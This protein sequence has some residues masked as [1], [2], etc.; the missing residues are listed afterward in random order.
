MAVFPLL[1]TTLVF[2]IMKS[3]LLPLACALLMCGCIPK[4]IDIEL[5][6]TP[7]KLVVA[8]QVI[9]DN[10]LVVNLTRSFN[11]LEG[12]Q[13]SDSTQSNT[14]FIKKIMVENAVVTVS[15][16]G[17]TDTLQ[18]VSP[19]IY[20]SSRINLYPYSS[21]TLY[22]YDPL[23]N[24]SVT[25][26]SG[27]IPRKTFDTIYPQVI[28]NPGD[29][30]IRIVHEL[31]DDPAAENYYVINYIY[32]SATVSA[33]NGTTSLLDSPTQLDSKKLTAAEPT[34]LSDQ[35]FTNGRY[36]ASKTLEF[37][38]PNDSIAVILSHI[39]KDYFDYL[40][41]RKRAGSFI[42]EISKEP[43]NYPTNVQNGY[44]YFNLYYPN[45]RFFDLR[46]Y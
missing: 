8:S 28:K 19:G 35:S 25:A 31:S 1:R 46:K 14:D 5:K 17:I 15:Y 23:L 12:Q 4:P 32:K 39:S 40:T 10:I 7:P 11:S 22:A 3:T 42:N 20:L 6:S 30:V 24:Q 29:T 27:M 45:F 18:M 41:I 13:A 33:L 37:I 16:A 43:L 38:K 44:G 26:S 36:S 34:L 9:S 2:K 21:Y